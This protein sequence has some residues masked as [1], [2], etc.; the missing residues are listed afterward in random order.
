MTDSL[1]LLIGTVNM[2]FAGLQRHFSLC[3]QAHAHTQQLVYFTRIAQNV[4]VDS[5]LSTPT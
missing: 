2:D 1:T 5:I 3:P 4:W